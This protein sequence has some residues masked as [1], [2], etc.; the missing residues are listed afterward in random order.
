MGCKNHLL[1]ESRGGNQH[2][3]DEKGQKSARWPTLRRAGHRACLIQN[4]AGQAHRA[5]RWSLK[6]IVSGEH[7]GKNGSYIITRRYDLGNQQW[8]IPKLRELL[9]TILPQK[10]TFEDYE[11]EHDFADIGRRIMLLNARQ[12]KRV[13]GK[14]RIILL[15]IEDI[16]ERRQLEILLADSEKR[17]R[18]L[19]ETANDGIL[20]LEKHDGSI[21]QANPAIIMMLGYSKKEFGKDLKDVGFPDD[22]SNFIQKNGAMLGQHEFAISVSFRASESAFYMTE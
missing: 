19:F 4:N 18:H 22:V 13:W 7:H 14:E 1:V 9:E 11:V 6:I 2:I 15:A 17:Y 10:T 21:A 12:I 20:L 8:D 16:T 5:C 3:T